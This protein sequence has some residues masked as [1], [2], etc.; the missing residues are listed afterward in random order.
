MTKSQPAK[1]ISKIKELRSKIHDP[2]STLYARRSTLDSL[3]SNSSN[4]LLTSGLILMAIWASH[5]YLYQRSLAFDTALREQHTPTIIDENRPTHIYIP[6]KVDT[7]ISPEVFV[8]GRWT[9]SEET[10]SHLVTFAKPGESGNIIIYGHNKREIMGNIRAMRTGQTITLTTQDGLKHEY[11]VTST[12]QV[13]PQKTD[14][15]EPTDSEILTLYTCAGPLDS[16][17]FIVRAKPII[18]DPNSLSEL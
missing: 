6:W 1:I 10:A 5:T 4:L 18:P 14:F 8:N 9:V 2:R 11:Y 15:L 17:R 3:R 16:Q 7:T 12:H 13:S